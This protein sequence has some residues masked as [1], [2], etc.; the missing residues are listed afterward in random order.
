MDGVVCT[1]NGQIQYS[2]V[3]VHE[4]VH[5]KQHVKG[6]GQVLG[7]EA[8]WS[9]GVSQ[10]KNSLIFLCPRAQAISPVLHPGQGADPGHHSR[11][12]PNPPAHPSELGG[13]QGLPHGPG[14]EEAGVLGQTPMPAQARQFGMNPFPAK[15]NL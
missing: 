15:C 1:N 14:A 9:V 13:L 7:N 8:Q 10:M 12:V 3:A 4:T 11:H 6:T 5:P 2:G